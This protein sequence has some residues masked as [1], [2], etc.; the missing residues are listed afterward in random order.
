MDKD[1]TEAELRHEDQG[2]SPQRAHVNVDTYVSG[3]APTGAH[4]P[5][6]Y[7]KTARTAEISAAGQMVGGPY[8][9]RPTSRLHETRPTVRLT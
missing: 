6:I 1:G 5:E 9:P 2:P 8:W 3:V 7:P 4:H